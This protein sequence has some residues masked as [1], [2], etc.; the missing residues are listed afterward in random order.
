MKS[1]TKKSFLQ[2]IIITLLVIL[3]LS[4][5]IMPTISKAEEDV[6]MDEV[7]GVLFS[8]IQFLVLGIGDTL[9]WIANTCAYGEEVDPIMTLSES[10][11]AFS[12][13]NVALGLLSRR[14][15]DDDYNKCNISR[16]DR[17]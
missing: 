16:N 6:D 14:N 10:W 13:T 15:M 2:K 9:L 1:F 11:N 17:I 8:P 7:G 4:N 5:F 12:I 3:I